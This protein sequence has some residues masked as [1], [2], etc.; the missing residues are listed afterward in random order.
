MRF[1]WDEHKNKSNIEKHDID[2]H[3][4]ALIFSAPMSVISDDRYDY[5][6]E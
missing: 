3:D 4:A 2:F 6:E 1:E 5:G